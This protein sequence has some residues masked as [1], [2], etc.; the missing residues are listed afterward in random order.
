MR[1]AWMPLILFFSLLGPFNESGPGGNA[2]AAARPKTGIMLPDQSDSLAHDPRRNKDY[3]KLIPDDVYLPGNGEDKDFALLKSVEEAAALSGKVRER[4][5]E[6]FP[7]GLTSREDYPLA[8][9]GSPHGPYLENK[10]TAFYHEYANLGTSFLALNY[11]HDTYDYGDKDGL[12]DYMQHSRR[13]KKVS[14]AQL[15]LG[16]NL[17]W[18]F[19]EPFW[20]INLG[21][22]Y[23]R[24]TG[25]YKSSGAESRTEFILWVVPLEVFLGF[26]MNLSTWFKLGGLAG[27][28]LIGLAQNR[29]DFQDDH[30]K[31]RITQIGHGYFMQGYLKLGLG[32]WFPGVTRNL[33]H[34]YKMTNFYLQ[35]VARYQGW[36]HFRE[37]ITIKGLSVGLG[38]AFDF[39]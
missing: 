32:R 36:N 39:R 38:L 28:S 33:Y 25:R 23:L 26:S 11:I 29:N 1:R 18:K 2:W 19:L 21:V 14:G 37:P 31:K 9:S 16:K 12:F 4:S 7:K 5:V 8:A 13:H 17:H 30:P 10:D 15:S 34:S 3:A 22:G 27:P 35:L 6:E 20:G 24:G